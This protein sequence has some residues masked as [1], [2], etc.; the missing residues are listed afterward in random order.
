VNDIFEAKYPVTSSRENSTV[1]RIRNMIVELAS[2][3]GPDWTSRE[4]RT[5]PH[6][7]GD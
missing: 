1:K 2:R 7:R 3:S 6:S 5:R 4:R